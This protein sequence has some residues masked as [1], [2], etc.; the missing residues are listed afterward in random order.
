MTAIEFNS[1]LLGPTLVSGIASAGL[2]G[3][4]AIALVLTYRVSRTI[5]FVHGGIAIFSALTYWWATG[6]ALYAGPTP[7]MPK[8]LAMVLIVV[9]GGLVGLA[10]GALVTGRRMAD[11]PKLT[12]TT[13]SLGVMLLMAGIATVIFVLSF[14][15]AGHPP[16]PFGSKLVR[17]AGFNVTVHQLVTIGTI[18]VV[19][20]ALGLVMTRTR[21]G[22]YLRALADDIE[23]SRWVGVPLHTVGTGVYAIS[24]ALAALSGVLIAPTLGPNLIDV[25]FVFL[26]ALSAAVIGGFSSFSLAI[27]GAIFFG[28]SDTALRSGL[29][30]EVTPGQREMVTIGVV[31]L[32]VIVLTRYRRNLVELLDTEAA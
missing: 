25:Y 2:Y 27:A 10:Y 12:L 17:I 23:A 15:V 20:A 11:W 3:M 5:A 31:L 8:P 6:P 28:V 32:A 9:A 29:L 24:G 26:R 14:G 18:A 13:F 1:V 21:T 22:I 19:A 16:S 30:G 7:N 4:L